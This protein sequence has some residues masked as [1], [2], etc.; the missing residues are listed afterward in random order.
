MKWLNGILNSSSEE[1]GNIIYFTEDE[2]GKLLVIDYGDYRTLNFDSPFEQSAMIIEQPY[3]L[4]HQ[5]TQLMLL[6]LAFTKPSH[7]TLFGLGGGSLLRTL[8]HVL[9]ECTFEIFELRQKVVDIAYEYFDIPRNER[10]VKVSI[11]D[12]LEEMKTCDSNST[13]IIFS[14]MYDA[15]RMVPEQIQ[16]E[17]L[18]NCSRLLTNKGWLVINLH[19]LPQDQTNFFSLLN[20]IFP[21]IIVSSNK[22][23]TILYLSN[24]QA[25]DIYTDLETLETAELL[26]QQSLTPLISRLKAR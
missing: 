1:Y 10:R 8:H 23:N 6:V 9:P 5:Y 25:D 20:E 3:K 11:S 24:S 26:L 13:D 2:H 22:I 14:D 16:K 17:F 21:T 15:Y 7:I 12:V 19:N 18:N 4:V